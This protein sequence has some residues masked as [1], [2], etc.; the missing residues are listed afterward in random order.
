MATSN[1][2][3]IE[4]EKL[5]FFVQYSEHNFKRPYLINCYLGLNNRKDCG[6][7]RRN[8]TKTDLRFTIR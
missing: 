4:V 1:D 3:I 7:A 5:D 8:I 6:F 2:D